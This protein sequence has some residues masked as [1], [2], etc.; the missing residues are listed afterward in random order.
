MMRGRPKVLFF[1]LSAILV[2]L[3][4]TETVQDSAQE[5]QTV[6]EVVESTQRL[7]ILGST[8]KIL[9]ILDSLEEN[10]TFFAP[11]D[12]AFTQIPNFAVDNLLTLNETVD[13]EYVIHHHIAEGILSMKNA[14]NMTV[15][16]LNGKNETL[17]YG[18]GN[19]TLGEANVVVQDIPACN[20]MVQIVDELL[21]P[22]EIIDALATRKSECKTIHDVLSLNPELSIMLS[23]LEA[24]GMGTEKCCDD[25]TILAPTNAAFE[26]LPAE[27]MNFLMISSNKDLLINFLMGHVF[28]GKYEEAG[29][30]SGTLVMF[31]NE[32]VEI[33]VKDD[34]VF[35]GEAE[36]VNAGSEVCTGIIHI[37]DVVLLPSTLAEFIMGQ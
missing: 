15:T 8:S 28:P 18:D 33:V 14:T 34:T 21:L 4:A 5:C 17:R 25:N 36:I 19:I 26:R 10:I 11:M 31:N 9:Q 2:A 35:V 12:I 23:V 7:S 24:V 1:L 13:M 16:M 3:V 6:S 37:I 29:F 32:V 22:D 30:Y 27:L 20:G